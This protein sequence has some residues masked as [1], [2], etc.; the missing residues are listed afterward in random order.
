MADAMPD[1][2]S[3]EKRSQVMSRIRGRGNQATEMALARLLR[4]DGITG[5]R[6][7]QRLPGRPDFVFR[8]QRVAV[9][10]DGCFWHAC[11]RHSTMP[12]NNRRFWAK[13]L[14]ANVDRDRLVNSWLRSDGWRVIRI[15]EHALVKEPTRCVRRIRNALAR[16]NS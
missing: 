2:F 6:R 8:R 5:W 1:V 14:R 16:R 4:L 7:H 15:W 11:P 13:K 3:P 9:F 10:V 12:V